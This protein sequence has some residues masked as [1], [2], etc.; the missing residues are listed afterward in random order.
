MN[1]IN[2]LYDAG[3]AVDTSLPLLE[4]ALTALAVVMEGLGDE[5]LQP[6]GKMS[7]EKALCFAR[8]FPLYYKALEL[9]C[10]DMWATLDSFQGTVDSIYEAHWTQREAKEAAVNAK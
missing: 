10:R 2:D 5:G 8:R 9:I 3:A 4:Q 7:S 1:E 6:E